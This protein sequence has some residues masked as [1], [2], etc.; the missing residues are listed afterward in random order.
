VGGG[1]FVDVAASNG[2][3]SSFIWPLLNSGSW[4]GLSVEMD[5]RKFAKLSYLYSRFDDVNLARIKV[6]PRNVC[7]LLESH[8]VG[9]KFELLN[10][11][12]DSYDLAVLEAML[13]GGFRP[14]VI[15]MEINEKIPPPIMFEVRYQDDHY[16]AGDHFYGCSL[17]SAQE[18]LSAYDYV[19][20]EMVGGN[21]QFV[22]KSLIRDGFELP[23]LEEAYDLGYRHLPDR[24]G[25][26]FY[27][28]DVDHW[29]EIGTEAA[30][31]QIT[32]FFAQYAGQFDLS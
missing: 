1:Y 10:L 13:N 2:V 6:T 12:I 3:H 17:A 30:K 28:S 22:E 21:A 23:S 15:S 31:S 24:R 16:W 5:P 9:H 32:G 11:D 14:K 26:F 19:L 7:A 8:L 25:K 27:N 29:L 18:K 4:A 20:K